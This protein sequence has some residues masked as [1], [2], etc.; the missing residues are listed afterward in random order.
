MQLTRFT[1]YT[2]RTLLVLA[3]REGD[4]VSVAEIA[5][6]FDISQN[7]LKK[8]AQWL[9]A[10]GLASS[11]RGRAGGL[12]LSVRPQEVRIGELVQRVEN[13]DLLECFDPATSMCPLTG[14]CSLEQALYQAR[15]AFLASLDRHTLASLA[16]SPELVVALRLQR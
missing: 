10:E 15:R 4:V 5:N 13:L 9:V 7:H 14:A 1:D 12:T 11:V 3:A 2:L 8:V 6:A 16:R